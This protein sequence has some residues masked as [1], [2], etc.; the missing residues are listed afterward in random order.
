[1]TDDL[2][3]S[4]C[5]SLSSLLIMG[6]RFHCPNGHKLNVKSELAGKKAI[7]P[8]CGAKLVVPAAGAASSESSIHQDTTVGRF[9]AA[10]AGESRIIGT[11][12][13]SVALH[14]PVSS[15]VQA[16]E[17]SPRLAAIKARSAVVWYIRPVSGGQFGPVDDKELCAWIADGRLTA[18]AY[19]WRAG[20][21][22]WLK[23]GDAPDELPT[24][25]PVTTLIELPVS[26]ASEAPVADIGS[27]FPGT[28]SG[29]VA[30]AAPLDEL[31]VLP[32][33]G[34]RRPRRQ[35]PLFVTVLLIL[36]IVVLAGVLIWVIQRN[37]ASEPP[38]PQASR[39]PLVESQEST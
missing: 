10:E 23:A 15:A 1:M 24:S 36:A 2:I 37:A 7:C 11:V 39:A 22:D 35:T 30:V 25:L 28:P 20:W 19:V 33:T 31:A 6:I 38:A 29:P 13:P 12:A 17:G 34:A 9:G 8:D 5:V 21:P 4:V 32:I 14:N 3:S 27:D 26:A 16:S 18:D